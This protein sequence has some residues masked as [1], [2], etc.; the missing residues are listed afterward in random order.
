MTTEFEQDLKRC[1]ADI[2]A[3]RD[4]LLAVVRPLRDE[5]LDRGSRGGWTVRRVLEHIIWH[6]LIYVRL[7][8]H[9]RGWPVPRDPIESTPSSAADA[10]ERLAASRA[11]LLQTVD[12]VDE[13]SFYRLTSFGQEEY[14]LLSMLE[15]ETNHER[16]HAEQIK[17]TVAV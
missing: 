13:E 4:E 14:S 15:N 3:A 16:E 5:D 8:T 6:E 2:A 11:A 1:R 10:L 7:S 17:K 9:I 12:G